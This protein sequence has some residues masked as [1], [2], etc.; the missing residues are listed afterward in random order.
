MIDWTWLLSTSAFA[1]AMSATPGPNNTM[2]VASG[3]TYGFARTM[4]HMLGIA[5]GFPVMLIMLR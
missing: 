3:A 4:P 1:V 2:V 5:A